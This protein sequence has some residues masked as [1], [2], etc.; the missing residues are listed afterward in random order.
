MKRLSQSLAN[1]KGRGAH[2]ARPHNQESDETLRSREHERNQAQARKGH[3]AVQFRVAFLECTTESSHTRARNTHSQTRTHTTHLISFITLTALT[4][5]T[6][7]HAVTSRLSSHHLHPSIIRK[8]KLCQLQTACTY[9][10]VS[11]RQLSSLSVYY[12]WYCA[13]GALAPTMLAGLIA[14]E[15]VYYSAQLYFYRRGLAH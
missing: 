13:L 3:F 12:G 14:S 7:S 10:P 2:E 6:R 5:L 8:L 15:I 4:R 11:S 1:E 9:T